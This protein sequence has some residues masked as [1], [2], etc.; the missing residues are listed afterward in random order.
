MLN[1]KQGWQSVSSGRIS[2]YQVFE[3]EFKQLHCHQ[4]A[5]KKPINQKNNV[6]TIPNTN[7]NQI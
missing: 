4:K 5:K 6:Q 1:T 7:I 2:A 3:P